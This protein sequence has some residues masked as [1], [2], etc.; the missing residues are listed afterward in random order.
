[1]CNIIYKQV[2]RLPQGGKASSML[3]DL[4][5]YYIGRNILANNYTFDGYLYIILKTI[6]IIYDNLN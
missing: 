1:M 6:I 5:V 4:Y 3:A 2:V